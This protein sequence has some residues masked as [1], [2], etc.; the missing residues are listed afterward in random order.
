[1]RGTQCPGLHVAEELQ[2]EFI[3][4]GAGDSELLVSD[5]VA[6][7]WGLGT[8]ISNQFVGDAA[9]AGPRDPG[10]NPRFSL[11]FCVYVHSWGERRGRLSQLRC[12]TGAARSTVL[13]LAVAPQFMFPL[14]FFLQPWT[15][16]CVW[17][18]EHC[19]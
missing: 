13:Q 12:G 5:S 8:C 3:S 17:L 9:A 19:T 6:W 7:G 18:M 15:D 14:T 16:L 10:G 1:M 2:W 11:P 4:L